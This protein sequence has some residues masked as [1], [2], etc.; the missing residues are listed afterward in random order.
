M[1]FFIGTRVPAN[2]KAIF[3]L[4]RVRIEDVELVYSADGITPCLATM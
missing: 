3:G 2:T 4:V 1:R